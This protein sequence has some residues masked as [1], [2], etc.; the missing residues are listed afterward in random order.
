MSEAAGGVDSRYTRRSFLKDLGALGAVGAEGFLR[1]KILGFLKEPQRKESPKFFEDLDHVTTEQIDAVV[2]TVDTIPTL[3]ANDVEAKSWHQTT[4]NA[5]IILK[6]IK[7]GYDHLKKSRKTNPELADDFYELGSAMDALQEVV[8]KYKDNPKHL[9]EQLGKLGMFYVNPQGVESD[10]LLGDAIYR[11]RS[12]W[13]DTT[14]TYSDAPYTSP[15]VLLLKTAGRNVFDEYVTGLGYIVSHMTL[16]YPVQRGV[17]GVPHYRPDPELKLLQN[18]HRKTMEEEVIVRPALARVTSP[19]ASVPKQLIDDVGRILEDHGMERVVNAVEISQNSFNEYSYQQRILQL[20]SSD[21]ANVDDTTLRYIICHEIGH[22]VSFL[23]RYLPVAESAVF[24][25]KLLRLLAPL[26]HGLRFDEIF[27]PKGTVDFRSGEQFAYKGKNVNP[28]TLRMYPVSHFFRYSPSFYLPSAINEDPNL[29]GLN[30]E[31][32][33]LNQRLSRITGKDIG[34]R[35]VDKYSPLYDRAMDRVFTTQYNSFK[36]FFHAYSSAASSKFN[37]FERYLNGFVA[38]HLKSIDIK[39]KYF[40]YPLNSGSKYAASGKVIGNEWYGFYLNHILPFVL[41]DRVMYDYENV[42]SALIL[43]MP[44]Y[45]TR[46]EAAL[47]DASFKQKADRLLLELSRFE[48]R[49]KSI[50]RHTRE[51]LFA[52]VFSAALRKDNPAVQVDE[53]L[54]QRL[55]DTKQWIDQA[56]AT[57]RD[58]G[59]AMRREE[60]PAVAV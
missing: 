60:E 53:D 51:E 48:K 7:K 22:A 8:R 13:A 11:Y 15:A 30:W 45:K 55:K 39:D 31:L 14:T 47:F 16:T 54:T 44:E 34:I 58:Q 3:F 38:Q 56:I 19:D 25:D 9:K 35:T 27:A 21:I 37:P 40:N 32:N 33:R 52:E 23:L 50:D 6:D 24:R 2:Q 59:M 43:G 42:Q 10:L 28:A 29:Y 5:G 18:Q 49:L 46:G 1:D 17:A 36:E 26:D 4:Q 12:T 20:Q 57:L 41:A